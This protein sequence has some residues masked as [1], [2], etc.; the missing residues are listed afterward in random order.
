MPPCVEGELGP[1]TRLPFERIFW[2]KTRAP[3][4]VWRCNCCRAACCSISVLGIAASGALW[5]SSIL[6]KQ[7]FAR[8]LS[9][10]PDGGL[11]AC[12]QAR[13]WIFRAATAGF[14][15]CLTVSPVL[16]LAYK[17]QE[18]RFWRGFLMRPSWHLTKLVPEALISMPAS[19]FI[20]I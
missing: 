11:W 2:V 5:V 8:P 18:N 15:V 17:I 6:Q 9:F 7:A 20:G 13:V 12:D 1:W 16:K 3:L 19:H 14:L 10:V 4:F